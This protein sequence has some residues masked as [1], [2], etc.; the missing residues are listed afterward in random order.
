MPPKGGGIG[1]TAGFKKGGFAKGDKEEKGEMPFE[2]HAKG[3]PAGSA[4]TRSM[5]AAGKA[6]TSRFEKG[7]EV[8][9]RVARDTAHASKSG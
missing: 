3:G 6:S 8:K 5:G 4:G 7:G 1:G 2:K 9:G